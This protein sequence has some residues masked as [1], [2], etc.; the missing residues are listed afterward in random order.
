MK[1]VYLSGEKGRGMYAIVDDADYE[2]LNQFSWSLHSAGYAQRKLRFKGKH[3]TIL[4]HRQLIHSECGFEIA[5]LDGN[6]LNNQRSNL[7][8][9]TRG[10]NRHN[11]PKRKTNTSGFKGVSRDKR[12]TDK[13]WYAK[14][15][16]QNNQ[17][18]S[19]YFY[20]KEEA[21][22]HYDEMAKKFYGKFAI[23]NFPE[24]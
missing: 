20:T 8:I 22:H 23:L 2:F 17:Y 14:I 7:E 16:F 21:A 24:E 6:P 19:S 13:C 10:E 3:I 11:T 18:M 15:Q 1:K 9:S 4:M 5:H 12:A